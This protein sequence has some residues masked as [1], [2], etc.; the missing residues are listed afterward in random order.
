MVSRRQAIQW[1]L[2]GLA[3]L[4][5]CSTPVRPLLLTPKGAC[6]S[7][8]APE[9]SDT[10]VVLNARFHLFNLRDLP[11]A[12]LLGQWSLY[13]NRDW[14]LSAQAMRLFGAC[15]QTWA[16]Q[17]APSLAQERAATQAQTA[18]AHPAVGQ[19]EAFFAQLFELTQQWGKAPDWKRKILIKQWGEGTDLKAQMVQVFR[20]YGG[21]RMEALVQLQARLAEE[22]PGGQPLAGQGPLSD[23]ARWAQAHADWRGRILSQAFEATGAQVMAVGLFHGVPWLQTDQTPASLAPEPLSEQM[24]H[25]QTL[26]TASKGRILPLAPFD[27]WEQVVARAQGGEGLLQKLSQGQWAGV[28]IWPALGFRPLGNAK[29][30]FFRK[31]EVEHF[32]VQLDA[33]LGELFEYCAQKGLPLVARSADHSPSGY[34]YGLRSAPEHWAKLFEAQ[35]EL[36]SRL[37]VNLAQFGGHW[38]AIPP[39]NTKE[40]LICER[41]EADRKD[42]REELAQLMAC[43]PGLYADLGSTGGDRAAWQRELARLLERYPHLAHRL[44]WAADASW[45]GL[46]LWSAS[47]AKETNALL[48]EVRPGL[49]GAVVR[50][51]GA[52]FFGLSG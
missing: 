41:E 22:A 3:T 16:A 50:R 17:T 31:P 23:L 27:P 30:H 12:D 19:G 35:P 8:E 20:H 33:V 29:L 44:L 2:M 28:E 40:S 46:A 32:G 10:E 34:C 42:W 1:G 39:L 7:P 6:P 43:V 48:E 36:K 52:R 45:S 21:E 47:N 15:V 38:A 5:G 26:A 11:L 51:N 24:E 14:P 9:P 25:L 4:G 37:K 49:G 18:Q 13:G